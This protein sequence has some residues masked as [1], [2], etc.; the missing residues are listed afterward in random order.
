MKSLGPFAYPMYVV[1]SESVTVMMAGTAA[2]EE[3]RPKRLPAI[4][5]TPGETAKLSVADPVLADTRPESAATPPDEVADQAM[6]PTVPLTP[7][8]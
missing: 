7:F 8:E 1:E 6:P 4:P 3:S 2:Q 5:F